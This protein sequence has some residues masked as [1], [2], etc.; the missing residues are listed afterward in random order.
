MT[1]GVAA[2]WLAFHGRDNLIARYQNDGVRLSEVF[3]TVIQRTADPAPRSLFG[4]FRGIVNAERALGVRLPEPSEVQRSF[5]QEALFEGID[6]PAGPQ[7]PSLT[8]ALEILGE[9]YPEGRRHLAD[10]LGVAEAKLEDIADG[11]GDEL[12]FHMI[13]AKGRSGMAARESLRAP[14]IESSQLSEWLK[15]RLKAN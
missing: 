14:V 9:D 2:L 8:T 15:A 7:G 11:G 12:A 6:I 10:G 5:E 1:A 13:L 4:G 3:R